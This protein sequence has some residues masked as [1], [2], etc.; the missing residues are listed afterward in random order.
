MSSFTTP[1]KLE[2][3]DG[4]KW[5]VLE[6][7]VYRIGD[8]ASTDEIRVEA[9]FITDFASIPRI[10]WRILPPTGKYGKAA[11]THDANYKR[12]TNNRKWADDVF[13]EGMEVLGTPWWQR[14]LIYNAVRAFGWAAWNQH[15]RED[16]KNE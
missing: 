5:R 4:Q 9:G 7:F 3:I 14:Q 16:G 15:R 1:L 6:E 11:V 8:E 2:Y 13:L 12:G 10:F